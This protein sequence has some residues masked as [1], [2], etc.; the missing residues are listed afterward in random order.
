MVIPGTSETRWV[1]TTKVPL[2][3]KQGAVVVLMGINRDITE[4]KQTVEALRESQALSHSLLEQ[5]PMEI[6]RKD[7][8]GRFV[9][10]NSEFCR[11]KG[12]KA[13]E[14][15]GKIPSPGKSPPSKRRNWAQRGR[16][17]SMPPSAWI[18][19][20]RSCRPAN[21]LSG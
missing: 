8:E 11:N 4:M 19:M 10:V 12:M 5:L 6:F 15:L 3:D 20:N 18:I 17:P 2:R 1:Q 9:L 16:Q 14:F 7:R 21:P 13:E